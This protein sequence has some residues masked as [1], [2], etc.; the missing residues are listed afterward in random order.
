LIASSSSGRATVPSIAPCSAAHGLAERDQ[1]GGGRPA[2]VAAVGEPRREC[3]E[4]GAGI[5]GE[6]VV[7]CTAGGVQRV[8]Q[9]DREW[10]ISERADVHLPNGIP[11]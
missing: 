9:L 4:P 7:R 11:P 2:T 1:L 6:P 8:V 10:F 3:V 5:G